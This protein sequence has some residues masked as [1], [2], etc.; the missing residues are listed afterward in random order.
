MHALVTDSETGAV[1]LDEDVDLNGDPVENNEAVGTDRF[2][3]CYVGVKLWVADAV[4]TH[5]WEPD[6]VH[7]FIQWKDRSN[8]AG[9]Q[10]EVLQT[11]E[12][13]VPGGG[14]GRFLVTVE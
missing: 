6:A 3:A 4:K 13:P 5:A 7:V 10:S 14:I 1:I 2:G 8:S 11:S 12:R 9:Q